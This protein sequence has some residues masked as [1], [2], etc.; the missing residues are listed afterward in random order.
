MYLEE[1]N[2]YQPRVKL[3]KKMLRMFFENVYQGSVSE[4]SG[5]TG[6]PYNLLYNLAHG[7]ISSLSVENYRTIFDEDPPYQ[8]QKKVG[9]A[10]FRGMVRLWIYLNNQATEA[11][12]Y[13]EFFEDKNFRRVDYRIFSGDIKTVDV[14]LEEKMEKKFFGQGLDRSEIK[15][16]IE[17]FSHAESEERVYY[18]EIEPILEFIKEKSEINPSLV[19]NQWVVRYKS[20][21]LLTV[22]DN[23]YQNALALKEKVIKAL[24]S[25]SKFGID[26]LREEIYGAR[27][28]LTL[29]SEIEDELAFLKKFGGKSPRKYLGRS[30]T[31]YE[32]SKLKRIA[33]WRAERIKEDCYRLIKENPTFKLRDIPGTYQKVILETML[34]VL[35]SYLKKKVMEDESG[36]LESFILAPSYDEDEFQTEKYGITSMDQAAQALGITKT[37]FDLLVAKHSDLF[38]K[39]AR[40]H[41]KWYL[42]SLY[43]KKLSERG[44]FS[45]VKAKYESMAK[46]LENQIN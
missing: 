1:K 46:G 27:K 23:V 26:K 16:W 10:Y 6:L 7:R 17:E 22:P 11:L 21:E 35:R 24:S 13:K 38:R 32:K 34:S 45:L 14:R 12:L 3:T 43:L 28:G 20:G 4:L 36:I 40:Y 5:K 18:D 39:I 37:A 42:P 29:Y 33:S 44:R 8:R 9:G 31:H 2:A 19:L 15:K 41:E 25:G 30:R